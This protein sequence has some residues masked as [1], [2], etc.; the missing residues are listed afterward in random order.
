MTSSLWEEK[1]VIR[2]TETVKLVGKDEDE[3]RHDSGG[4]H[5]SSILRGAREPLPQSL[6]G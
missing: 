6:S 3:R 1:L 2:S 5:D 4:R